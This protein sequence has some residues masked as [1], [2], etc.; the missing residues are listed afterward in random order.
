MKILVVHP[1]ADW[2]T[3]DVHDGLVGALKRQGHEIIHYALNGRIAFSY[4]FLQYCWRKNGRR[5]ERPTRA[6][7]V[8]MAGSQVI[9]RALR[10]KVDWVLIISAM[11]LAPDWLVL[12][13]RAG[14][15][16]AVVFTE[17]PYDD[18]QLVRLAPYIDVCFTNE[19]TSVPVLR[20]ANQRTYYLPHAY[21]PAKHHPKAVDGEDA[22]AH[23][24]VFVGTGF[25]ERVQLLNAVNWDGI[26]LGLY[27]NWQMLGSRARLR[28]YVR[29]SCT[30]NDKTA[31]LYRRARIGLNLHRT[32]MEWGRNSHHI[33]TAESLN[34][35]A[36]EL[37]A[38]G[39]F[40]ISDYRPEVAEVFG[41]LVPT[42]MN[43][44]ELEFLI[45]GYLDNNTYRREIARAL[46]E[47]VRHCT[48]D[49]RAAQIVAE[50]EHVAS[51]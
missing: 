39:V 42:F 37:A 11:Y 13:R 34:P 33:T 47:A 19:R 30:D 31:E 28:R 29:G 24:V 50:L 3:A 44:T 26:D 9:E 20:Q 12:L 14:L 10:F 17:S 43:P 48:F 51:N 2:S 7:G 45:R 8:Y 4:G 21:D 25:E 15:K 32:T 6:D 27:G 5:Q 1:G 36:Y 49:E 40:T 22:P 35:R 46:P 18:A 16:T 23:D 41:S 38:C